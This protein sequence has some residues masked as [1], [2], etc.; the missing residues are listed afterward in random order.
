MNVVFGLLIAAAWLWGA[1]QA[2]LLDSWKVAATWA[3]G[4]PVGGGST[5]AQR[6]AARR[7]R[8]PFDRSPL[9]VECRYFQAS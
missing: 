4:L 6:F 2:L 9:K 1:E 7:D 5:Y 8:P 3:A